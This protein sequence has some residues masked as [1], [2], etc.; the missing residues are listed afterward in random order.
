MKKCLLFFAVLALTASSAFSQALYQEGFDTYAVGDYI[1]VVNPTWWTTWS[2]APGGSEDA[3]ISDEQAASPENSIKVDGVTDAILKMGNKTTGKYKLTFKLY[4]PAGF[5]GYYNI[6][7]YESPGVEWAYEVY[8]GETGAGYLSAGSAQVAAFNYDHD[9]WVTCENI[10]NLDDDWTQLYIGGNLIYE[11]PFSWQ[12]N[13][14]SGT[15]QLGGMDVYAGAPTGETPLYYMD[16]LIFEQMPEPLYA[17]DFESYNVGEYLAVQNP[18]WWT[19]WSGAPGGSEDALISDEQALSGSQSVKVDG[20]TDL[21]LKMGDKTSGKYQLKFHYYV[22]AG[23]GGYFNIQHFESPGVEWAYEVFFGA[24][25]SGYLNAGSVQVAVFNYDPDTWIEIDNYIDV[26]NDWTQ[27]YINGTL[28][29]EWPFSWQYNAQNGTNQLGGMDVWAGAPTG[30]TPLYYMDDLEFIQLEGGALPPTIGISPTIMIETINAGSTTSQTL[31][32]TNSG[33]S[34]LEYG[35]VVTYPE[36]DKAYKP[37]NPSTGSTKV[38]LSNISMDPTSKPG[39]SPDPSDDVTLHYDGDNSSAI[40]LTT[41]GAMRCA[42]VFTPV[43]VGEYI[44]MEL[45]EIELFIN[46]APISTKVQVYNYG[47]TSLPGPG[48]L[49]LEQNFSSISANWNTVALNDPVLISGGDIWVGYWVNHDAGTFPA[50]CDAGP[51][52]PNGDWISS[53]PGWH[54]LSDSPTL[55]FNWNIRAV[56]TGES[57]IQWLSVSSQSGTVAVG[58]TEDVE[59]YFDATELTPG[60]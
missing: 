29:Y 6:Q 30:E 20:T 21:V 33:E 47:T 57:I 10:F 48:E 18:D 5:G 8:F 59:V 11:W 19:T 26:T 38:V 39:G 22:P 9:A 12:A 43:E 31:S 42:A 4:V 25:G 46:D 53:G 28:L 60:S 58:G 15:L 45:S 52:H 36:N 34:D 41:G 37:V 50:G 27:L 13:S 49:I 7:H 14:Q 1:A 32:I 56:L 23:Y 35:I 40:G 44:G 55:D 17:D 3:V 2:G 16:D 24:T 54:H 51:H